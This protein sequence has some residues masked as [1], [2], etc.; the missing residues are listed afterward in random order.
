MP[1]A[2]PLF[3]RKKYVFSAGDG[4]AEFFDRKKHALD[5]VRRTYPRYKESREK[6]SN[7]VYFAHGRTIFSVFEC[8]VVG[9][10]FHTHM[11][12]WALTCNNSVLA[13]SKTPSLLLALAE[14][15]FKVKVESKIDD[16][17]FLTPIDK[18]N[19][20]SEDEYCVIDALTMSV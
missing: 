4:G 11:M 16:N 18:E 17:W 8:P 6:N 5:W 1:R 3:Q 10:S 15:Q 19:A 20:D 9:E 7:T 14:L 2:K 12:F 13:L